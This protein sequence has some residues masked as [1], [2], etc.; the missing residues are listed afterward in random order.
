MINKIVI[1]NAAGN[2]R[3]CGFPNCFNWVF[4]RENE[5][6]I[7]CP[8]C[9]VTQTLAPDESEGVFPRPEREYWD[10][11]NELPTYSFWLVDSGVR[12]VLDTTGKWFD[13]D[14]ARELMDEAQTEINQLRARLAV[15]EL[16]GVSTNE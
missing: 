7:R 15:L 3:Q 5:N 12:A 1:L 2:A 10:R 16:K 6:V 11:I 9:S 13:A 8:R 14:S 4:M